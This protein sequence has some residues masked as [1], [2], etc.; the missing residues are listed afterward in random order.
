MDFP[1]VG[2][3]AE[4]FP[5]AANLYALVVAG[6]SMSGD[7]ILDGD[8]V[9]VNPELVPGDGDIVAIRLTDTLSGTRG[10]ALGRLQRSGTLLEPSNPQFPKLNLRPANRAVVEGVVVGMARITSR[11]GPD[12]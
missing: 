5:E 8:H 9:L 1:T 12:H 4:L 7:G 6:D 2:V 11:H 10:L 3:P